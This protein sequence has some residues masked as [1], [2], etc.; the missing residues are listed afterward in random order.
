MAGG[1][2]KKPDIVRVRFLAEW[3]EKLPAGEAEFAEG[4]LRALPARELVVR[5]PGRSLHPKDDPART[6][7]WVRAAADGAGDE[8]LLRG[9]D[10]VVELGDGLVPPGSAWLVD[11]RLT[12]S[13]GRANAPHAGETEIASDGLSREAADLDEALDAVFEWAKTLRGRHGLHRDLGGG[14][15]L[16]VVEPGDEGGQGAR[17]LLSA[18]TGDE[19][20]LDA[21][22]AMLQSL[23]EHAE[24]RYGGL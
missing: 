7:V 12:Y 23:C 15:S 6:H 9:A 13:Q 17:R 3:V 14:A 18:G 11:C 2:A 24:R 20:G 19:K 21:V 5:R 8:R 16:S 1:K 4:D 22:L 10:L